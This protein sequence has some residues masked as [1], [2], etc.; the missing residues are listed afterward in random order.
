MIDKLEATELKQEE[1]AV[2][3]PFFTSLEEELS[4]KK[5]HAQELKEMPSTSVFTDQGKLPVYIG[6]DSGSTTS[7]IVLMDESQNIIESF[8]AN[9]QGEPLQVVKKG[10]LDI[11]KK[12]SDK[13]IELEVS[14]VGTT[15]YGENLLATAFGADYHTVE[16]VAHSLGCTHYYPDTSFILDIG[17]QDMKAI[18]LKDGIITNIMLNEACSSGCGSFLENF[19]ENLNISVKDISEA[20]FCSK[21]PAKLGSRCTVF[22]NSTNIPAQREGKIPDDIMAGHCRSIVENVF[23]KVVRL[24]NTDQLGENIVCARWYF[25]KSGSSAGTGRIS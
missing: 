1:N 12:Y 8:Y 2:E 17:G 10:L 13:G 22:M 18:W 9:N 4:F 7:K 15:G 19:A 21:T 14:G 16:T 5:R 6:I 20:A 3:P 24:S 25:P 23:T 11:E